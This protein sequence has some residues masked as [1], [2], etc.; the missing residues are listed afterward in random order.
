K[1]SVPPHGVSGIFHSSF[2][3]YPNSTHEVPIQF[4]PRI[5]LVPLFTDPLLINLSNNKIT[6]VCEIVCK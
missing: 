1:R 6:D 5:W 4:P 2:S 3:D